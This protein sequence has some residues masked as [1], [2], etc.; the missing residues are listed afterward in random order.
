MNQTLKEPQAAKRNIPARTQHRRG[1]SLT[2]E[3]N[4]DLFSQSRRSL[5]VASFN[6]SDCTNLHPFHYV[7]LLFT[8]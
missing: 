7:S 2:G 8:E 6:E 4:L 5:S 3:E 1:L